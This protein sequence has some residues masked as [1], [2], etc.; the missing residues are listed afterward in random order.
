MPINADELN[1]ITVDNIERS[2]I[3]HL[4]S[5][6]NASK[7]LPVVIVM[8]GGGGSIE[9][10]VKL[11]KMNATADKHNFIVVYPAGT[12]KRK[13]TLLTWNAGNCC[14]YAR[15]N[16]INDVKFIDKMI[17]NLKTVYNINEKSNSSSQVGW[18]VR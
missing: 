16:N 13:N 10:M 6:Y 4:P 18:Q 12:G 14:G 5:N 7:K 17:D 1:T 9:G 8:H 11:T 3:V 15:D 2:F